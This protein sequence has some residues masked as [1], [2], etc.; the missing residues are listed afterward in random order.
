MIQVAEKVPWKFVTVSIDEIDQK[1]MKAEIDTSCRI[2]TEH[3]PNL[4]LALCWALGNMG[5]L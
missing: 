4:Y 2:C 1:G 5:L 3:V